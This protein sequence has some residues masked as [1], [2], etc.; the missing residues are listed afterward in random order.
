V[1][2]PQQALEVLLELTRQLA[3]ERA[4]EESLELVTDAALALLDAADH[5]SVRL[6]DET[7]TT[8]LSG[9]RS[10]T[11]TTH[12]P[13]SFR[14]GEGVVGWVVDH[15]QVARLASV[16]E[17]PRYVVREEQGFAVGS[18]IAVPLWSNG[19]V[20]GVL[21]VSSPR[22]HAFAEQDELAISLL[23]NCAVPAIERARLV[24]LSVTDAQTRTFNRRYL[25]SRLSEEMAR[26]ERS[27][28][29]LSLMMIDLDHF[30]RVND[31]YGHPSG[32]VVLSEFA[33]RVRE[34]TRRQDIF[35][36]W[37]GEEFMLLMPDTPLETARQ[38]AERIRK[39]TSARPYAID[40]G[41]QVAQTVSIG[42]A[43][44][45]QFEA[46]ADASLY[47]AKREGR[48]RVVTA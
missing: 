24:R 19:V 33:D 20:V 38:V 15:A 21:A 22:V 40:D 30:K 37:G 3:D 17:D 26:S 1:I 13:L 32:D 2:A 27:G 28:A 11:G 35:V 34:A 10:G 31:A 45:D 14:P 8:L 4:L 7:R 6:L 16:S 39:Q 12:A 25:E 23:A 43:T 47:R 48:D 41:V 5:A 42:V 9:A 29:P 36:R 18:I 46:R 44:W